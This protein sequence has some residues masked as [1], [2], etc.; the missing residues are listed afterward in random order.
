MTELA[1]EAEDLALV[2]IKISPTLPATVSRAVSIRSLLLLPSL[3]R[4]Y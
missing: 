3:E 1:M 4:K 2:T